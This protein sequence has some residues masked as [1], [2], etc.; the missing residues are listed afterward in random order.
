MWIERTAVEGPTKDLPKVLSA[1]P[2][3]ATSGH[4]AADW[5][6]ALGS[7]AVEVIGAAAP[8]C[9]LAAEEERITQFAIHWTHRGQ[10]IAQVREGQGRDIVRV[11]IYESRRVLRVDRECG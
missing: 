11:K 6:V 3:T 5:F 2:H 1:H 10:N 8:S 4:S 9:A 7:T